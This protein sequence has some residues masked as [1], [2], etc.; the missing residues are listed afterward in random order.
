MAQ[1]ENRFMRALGW[2]GEG[3]VSLAQEQIYRDI[4]KPFETESGNM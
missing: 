1:M 4:V 3:L 2:K